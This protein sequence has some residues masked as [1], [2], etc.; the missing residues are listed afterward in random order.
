[1]DP[2]CSGRKWHYF[3]ASSLITFGS[4]LVVIST[5][6]LVMFFAH[7]GKKSHPKNT[8]ITPVVQVDMPKDQAKEKTTVGFSKGH[9]PEVGWLT[10]AKDWAGELISGQTTTGRIL[11]SSFSIP[12]AIIFYLFIKLQILRLGEFQ[13][14]CRRQNK[15]DSKLEICFGKEKK[16]CGKRRKFWLPAFSP[17]PTMFSKAFFSRYVKSQHCVVKS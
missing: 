9:D 12:V 3:L 13:S 16:H 4:G 7:K 17:F 8:I 15:C 14:I 1:M 10:E 6:R 2:D 5:Y 11:V